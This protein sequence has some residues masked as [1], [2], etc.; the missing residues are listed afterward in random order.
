MVVHI[1][2]TLIML[3][4]VSL[5]TRVIMHVRLR[6]RSLTILLMPICIAILTP[7][8]YEYVLLVCVDDVCNSCDISESTSGPLSKHY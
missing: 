6:I 3:T 8:A 2:I 4:R 1:N 7:I 5:P